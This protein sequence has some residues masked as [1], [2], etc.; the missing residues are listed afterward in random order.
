LKV[1]LY[2]LLAAILIAPMASGG[3]GNALIFDGVN[4]YVEVEDKDE[5]D[6][7]TDDFTVSAW[8][9][10]SH[11]PSGNDF[12][13]IISK[14]HGAGARSGYVLFIQP[15]AGIERKASFLIS[16][17]GQLVIVTS[18]TNINDGI[19]HHVAGIKT[20]S[21]IEI[22]VDG[23]SEGTLTHA[24]G[25]L[26]N[27]LPFSIG[28][29]A[30]NT[31]WYF[32]GLISEGRVW[33]YARSA[34]EI[35]ADMNQ[36]LTGS[37]ANLVAYWPLV[38]G[39]GQSI[40]DLAGNNPGQLGSS[41]QVDPSDPLWVRDAIPHSLAKG[42][43]FVFDGMDDWVGVTDN[44]A[45]DFD[46]G[47][48]T[49]SVWIRTLQSPTSGT[50]SILVG[51][52]SGINTARTGYDLV[53]QPPPYSGHITFELWSGGLQ[54]GI[55][56]SKPLNDGL[57]HHVSGVKTS[58]QVEMFVDGVSQGTSPHVLGT[59]SNDEPLHFG[60]ASAPKQWHY[61][62]LM[63]DVRIWNSA[64]TQQEIE[65]DMSRE[66]TGAEESLAGYWQFQEGE[67]QSTADSAGINDGQLGSSATLD[68][69]DPIW[70]S[71]NFPIILFKDGF[72][73]P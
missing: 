16:S 50:W 17:D 18:T 49:I 48:F 12:P 9:K 6:F 69:N 10:T 58:T 35:T 59:L 70:L 31:P 22:I 39:Q 27:D 26:S 44:D 42:N 24:L 38:E 23:V 29:A 19:W 73:S 45:F 66:L 7:G 20:G 14:E 64:R 11:T 34:A 41:A 21:E 52:E 25:T 4:D 61:Q 37:E 2:V 47:D 63:D 56:S 68:I 36:P 1:Q 72:E 46:T 55:G 43:A 5:L 28:R 30:A 54:A 40:A 67:G 51:K 71:T 65:T 13:I 53:L 60:S 33:G 8:I 62:G 15:A 57:W 3:Q 32:S